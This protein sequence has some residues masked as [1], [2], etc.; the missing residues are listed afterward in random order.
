MPEFWHFDINVKIVKIIVT[1]YSNSFFLC[2]DVTLICVT[3]KTYY[4]IHSPLLP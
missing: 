2:P 1:N 3:S 4:Q